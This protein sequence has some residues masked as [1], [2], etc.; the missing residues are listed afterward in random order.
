MKKHKVND[1]EMLLAFDECLEQTKS[2]NDQRPMTREIKKYNLLVVREVSRCRKFMAIMVLKALFK[3][4]TERITEYHEEKFMKNA[5]MQKMLVPFKKLR[6]S[7]ERDETVYSLSMAEEM[8]RELEKLVET[9]DQQLIEVLNEL[10]LFEF[11]RD[12]KMSSRFLIIHVY[13]FVL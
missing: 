10:Y 12:L 5:D 1:N 11:L 4:S 2:L 9:I 13:L 8:T 3:G 7:I 6:R